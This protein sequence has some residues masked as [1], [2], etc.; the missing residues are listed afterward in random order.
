[1]ESTAMRVERRKPLTANVGIVSVGLDTYWAQ[2]PGLLDDMRKKEDAF[3]RKLDG[4]SVS[5]TRFGTATSGR[6]TRS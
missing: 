3:V 6:T 1:M 2:C 5:V 4:L